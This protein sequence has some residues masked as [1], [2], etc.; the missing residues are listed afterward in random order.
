MGRAKKVVTEDSKSV[1]VF[2][3][4][5]EDI[6]PVIKIA[7]YLSREEKIVNGIIN[8]LA[9]NKCAIIEI[10]DIFEMVRDEIENQV[11]QKVKFEK[12]EEE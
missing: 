4:V 2:K 12:S 5:S 9:K 8:T 10:D 7:K 6:N 11:I 1:E 3:E